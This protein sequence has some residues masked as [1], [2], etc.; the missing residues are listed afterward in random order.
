M[1]ALELNHYLLIDC[2][3]WIYLEYV[4]SSGPYVCVCVCVYA[5]MEFKKYY[6]K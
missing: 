1:G 2:I 6:T 5:H 3:L 4:V